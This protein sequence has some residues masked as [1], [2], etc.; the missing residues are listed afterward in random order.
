MSAILPSK[1]YVNVYTA[2]AAQ[3]GTAYATKADADRMAARG[4]LACVEVD[5]S[6]MLVRGT[7]HDGGLPAFGTLGA[8]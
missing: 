2:F 3:V 7:V 6:G 4:R 1:V 8:P 5:L